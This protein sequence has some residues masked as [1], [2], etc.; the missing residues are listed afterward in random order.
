MNVSRETLEREVN[1]KVLVACEE[2]QRV[3]AAF[4]ERGHECYSCDILECSGNHPEWHIVADVIPLLPGNCEFKTCDGVTHTIRGKWDMILAFPPCTHLA[5]SGAAHFKKKR[6]SGVQRDGIEFFCKFLSVD[7]EKVAIENPIGIISGEYV[8][9]WYPDLAH[10]YNLPQKPTQ[11]IHPWQYGDSYEKSTCLWLKGLPQLKPTNIVPKGEFKEWVDKKTGK[12]KRQPLWFFEA[13]T[14]A[15]T[16]E[17][18]AKIR[19]KTF[20]GIAKAMAEQWGG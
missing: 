13:L 8:T 16:P 3:C 18:R 15:K 20:P 9:K 1:M 19:S 7:C 14:N 17:E 10:K 2:S 6:E 4:R 5:V 12:V 11:I